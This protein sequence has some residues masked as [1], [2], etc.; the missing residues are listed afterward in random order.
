M[1]GSAP[2]YSQQRE[3][4]GREGHFDFDTTASEPSVKC[5]QSSFSPRVLHV[6]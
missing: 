6:L 1:I 4:N 5:N 3:K 2:T